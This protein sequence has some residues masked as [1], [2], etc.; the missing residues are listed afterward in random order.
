MAYAV[1]NVSLDK[2]ANSTINKKLWEELIDILLIGHGP[3]TR[4]KD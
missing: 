4:R 1:K 2:A 3:Y